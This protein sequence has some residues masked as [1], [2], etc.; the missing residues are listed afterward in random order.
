MNLIETHRSFVNTWDCDENNHLNVQFYFQRF[1]EAAE[2]FHLK[3]GL[4]TGIA[5]NPAIRHVRFIREL[6]SNIGYSISST[7]IA[8]GPYAGNII[9]LLKNE[10]DGLI[11]ASA[12]D[13]ANTGLNAPSSA[14]QDLEPFLPRGV[15]FSQKVPTD[16]DSLLIS[17]QAIDACYFV[18]RPLHC[19]SAGYMLSQYYV[20]CFT[21]GA[22]HIWDH[23]GLTT[24]WL[25]ERGYG[26]IAM[27]MKVCILKPAPS[28]TPL[29][30]VTWTTYPGGKTFRIHHQIVDIEGK[31]T[32]ATAEVVSLIMDLAERKS[33][34]LPDFLKPW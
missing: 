1:S 33:V 8:D 15:E 34:P 6:R 24:P 9:H 29:R 22:P 30:L 13:T 21:D 32:F 5:G 14:S 27:E 19:D 16:L 28:D 25:E 2:I 20:S 23:I 26:R 11:S 4:N 3:Q 17:N 31:T 7:V 10:S 12:L 18:V